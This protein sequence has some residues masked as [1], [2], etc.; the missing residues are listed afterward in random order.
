MPFRIFQKDKIFKLPYTAICI[1]IIGFIKNIKVKIYDPSWS[2]NK[3]KKLDA[4][5]N[6]NFIWLNITDLVTAHLV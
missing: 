1:I 6:I 4:E 3:G 5:P 2:G